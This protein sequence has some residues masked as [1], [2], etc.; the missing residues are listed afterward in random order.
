MKKLERS[1][2]YNNGPRR[3]NVPKKWM[4]VDEPKWVSMPW[5]IHVLPLNINNSWKSKLETFSLYIYSCVVGLHQLLCGRAMRWNPF[6][7]DCPKTAFSLR[8]LDFLRRMIVLGVVWVWNHAVI[9]S[10]V[11][12][13]DAT[14]L[15]TPQRS[16]RG[17]DK[18]LNPRAVW[19]T[20]VPLPVN[21]ASNQP[22][23]ETCWH[24]HFTSLQ[25][26]EGNVSD[27]FCV[28]PLVSST[29]QRLHIPVWD[30]KREMFEIWISFRKKKR[31]EILQLQMSGISLSYRRSPPCSPK[32]HIGISN[33]WKYSYHTLKSKA[34]VTYVNLCCLPT[35]H[36]RTPSPIRC[37]MCGL[38]HTH[39]FPHPKITCVHSLFDLAPHFFHWKGI[40]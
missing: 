20:N 21:K 34:N 16:V 1:N 3:R 9:Y 5:H 33:P 26:F 13:F 2:E 7:V 8:R 23:E 25:I 37:F 15:T 27:R 38:F 17:K 11:S 28:A 14:S 39:Y 32:T 10:H 6:L 12:I 22:I 24:H 36:S 40:Q 19:S 4:K 30:P 31:W 35:C 29:T 18:T